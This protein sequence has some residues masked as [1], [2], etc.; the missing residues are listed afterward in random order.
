MLNC[1]A[2]VKVSCKHHC[3]SDISHLFTHPGPHFVAVTDHCN[4]SQLQNSCS[5]EQMQQRTVCW[6]TYAVK[7]SC[8]TVVCMRMQQCSRPSQTLPGKQFLQA[9]IRLVL[10]TSVALAA[11]RNCLPGLCAIFLNVARC[12]SCLAEAHPSHT[13]QFVCRLHQT[14]WRVS[15]ATT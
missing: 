9:A 2:A 10:H 1:S 12:F 13:V 11:C 3:Q 14:C 4:M 8:V 15:S 7:P 6:W 5:A